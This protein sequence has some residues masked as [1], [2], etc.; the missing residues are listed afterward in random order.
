MPSLDNDRCDA[1][2]EK[3]EILMKYI[4]VNIFDKKASM[5]ALKQ[6]VEASVAAK[7][8]DKL[9]NAVDKKLLKE[10]FSQRNVKRNDV[11]PVATRATILDE[12]VNERKASMP[13]VSSVATVPYVETKQF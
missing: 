3:L 7:L 9:Q 12:Y 4:R 8:G 6:S 2:L 11:A 13:Q 5:N 1:T 10:M